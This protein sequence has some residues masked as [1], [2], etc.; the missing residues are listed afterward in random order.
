MG[1]KL[2]TVQLRLYWSLDTLS[3]SLHTRGS[4][5]FPAQDNG[6]NITMDVLIK[7]KN[8]V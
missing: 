8:I 6:V 1:E 3:L 2:S 7:I 5:G 4:V